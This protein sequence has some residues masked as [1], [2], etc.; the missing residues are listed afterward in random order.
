MKNKKLLLIPVSL[1]LLTGCNV[2]EEEP[3]VKEGVVENSQYITNLK[4]VDETELSRLDEMHPLGKSIYNSNRLINA[5]QGSY[6]DYNRGVYTVKNSTMQ[7][8][9]KL[10]ALDGDVSKSK[11]VSSFKNS[12]GDNYLINSMDVYVRN[13]TDYVYGKDYEGSVRVNTNKMGYYYYEVNVRDFNFSSLGYDLNIEKTFHTYSDQLR[14]NYRAIASGTTTVDALGFETKILNENIVKVEY[15][16]G[17]SYKNL[18]ENVVNLTSIQY[19]AFHI[20]NVGVFG[21][22]FPSNPSIKVSIIKNNLV[23]TLRQ[24]TLIN[25]SK[26]VSGQDVNLANRIYNDETYNFSGIREAN[27]LE[28]NPYND[29]QI[30][31]DENID[32][33]N[34]NGYD[35]ARGAYT[36]SLDSMSFYDSYFVSPNK[37]F[38]EHIK[39]KPIDDRQ[40]YIYI[41]CDRPVEGATIIDE[42]GVQIP[43]PVEICKNFGHENEEPIYETGDPFYGV[44]IFPITVIKNKQLNFSLVSVMQNWG[45]YQI[46]QLSSISYSIGYYHMSTGVTETNCIAPYFCNDLK[47]YQDYGWSWFIPDFRGPSGKM[48]TYGDPQFNSVGIVSS[49]TNN[50]TRVSSNYLDTNISSSGLI[51]NDLSYSYISDDSNYKFTMRHVEMAQKD[52]SRTYYTI[53]FEI[54][55]DT[56]LKSKSFSIIGFDGRNTDYNKYAYLDENG[57]HQVLDAK[58]TKGAETFSILQK[59]SAY[60]SVYDRSNKGVEN[61]NFGLIVKDYSIESQNASN[62]SKFGLAMYTNFG[63][64]HAKYNYASLT[65]KEDLKVKAGDKIHLNLIL[66]PFGDEG[67]MTENGDNIIKV[68]NDSVKDEIMLLPSTGYSISDTYVPTVKAD[69]NNASFKIIGGSYKNYSV[70]YAINCVGYTKLGKPNITQIINNKSQTYA[71]SKESLGFDGYQ[72]NYKD[73]YFNYSFNITKANENLEFALS[74]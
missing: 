46:K 11:V 38:Y 57:T 66:L 15:F 23:T 37:K 36:F 72:V 26:V 2:K 59:G 3:P 51:Y 5:V 62:E 13:G 40:I 44:F 64:I 17:N 10:K 43:I 70:N 25:E 49:P 73:G 65:L 24:E 29:E 52:E 1:F 8:S 18:T 54:L 4:K 63:K 55:N 48:W 45:N 71:Y 69:N 68:Y 39:I 19:V 9:H 42:T 22:I 61:N 56:T 53:D 31:V 47:T 6:E 27:K 67:K 28:H 12:K 20:K 16:D 7:F 35:F 30:S 58:K 32:N 21:V 60:M 50:S 74:I 14:L 33:A 34:F 41:K